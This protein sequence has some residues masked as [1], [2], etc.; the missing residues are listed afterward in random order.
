MF[1]RGGSLHPN[2]HKVVVAEIHYSLPQVMLDFESF[3]V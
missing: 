2:I 3:R 1:A